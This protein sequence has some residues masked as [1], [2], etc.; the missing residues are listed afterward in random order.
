MRGHSPA[1]GI[2]VGVPARR[3]RERSRDLLELERRFMRTK[4]DAG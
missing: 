2:Y 1:F 3:L 4:G